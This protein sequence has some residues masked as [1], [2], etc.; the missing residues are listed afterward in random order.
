MK[1]LTVVPLDSGTVFGTFSI[2]GAMAR[3]IW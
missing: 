3:S 1:A 2:L